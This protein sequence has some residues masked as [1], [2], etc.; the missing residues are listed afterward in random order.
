MAGYYEGGRLFEDAETGGAMKFCLIG[1]GN[2]GALKEDETL[3][4]PVRTHLHAMI[5]MKNDGIHIH[6]VR[7]EKMDAAIK[8]WSVFG[9]KIT[10]GIS[11]DCDY[12]T[13][14][15]PA[16]THLFVV[17][18]IIR[19]KPTGI[20]GLI[21]E[22]PCGSNFRE[23]ME[24]FNLCER[25]RIPLYVNYQRR[26]DPALRYLALQHQLIE[27][28]CY[29]DFEWTCHGYDLMS[30]FAVKNVVI[31]RYP[32]VIPT[33]I[34]CNGVEVPRMLDDAFTDLYSLV[35]SASTVYDPVYMKVAC[36]GQQALFPHYMREYVKAGN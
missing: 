15:T 8:K 32:M 7:Q 5:K 4:T 19:Q 27:F 17:Q 28:M 6:D 13:V 31:K 10:K 11:A 33:Q 22:K 20:K 36:T 1:C 12:F 24:I 35:V 9:D 21:V 30:F 29:D 2:I 26:F 3:D 16:S 14:A 34:F 18:S 25:N 23:C